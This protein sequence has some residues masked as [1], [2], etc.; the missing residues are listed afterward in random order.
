MLK[1]SYDWG[2]HFVIE[3]NI[4]DGIPYVP[5]MGGG[6]FSSNDYHSKGIE[7]PN[8]DHVIFQYTLAGSCI[9][10]YGDTE[11]EVTA[12][13][14]FLCF[15]NDPLMSYR[16]NEN[17]DEN[18]Q[19]IYTAISG[20]HDFFRNLINTYGP[21]YRMDQTNKWFQR[22]NANWKD[23]VANECIKISFEENVSMI[24][25][26][27]AD[28]LASGRA[29]NEAFH[30]ESKIINETKRL[31]RDNQ[32]HHFSVNSLANALEIS[33][34]HLTRKC[35][36]E[37]QITAIQLIDR[38]KVEQATLLLKFSNM[39]IKEIA[40]EIGFSSYSSFLRTFK[41]VTSISPA[42]FKKKL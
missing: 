15:A 20:N 27:V 42:R 35:K 29:G 23:T 41:R 5:F 17:K 1:G 10:K 24:G 4:I 21:I 7:R 26:L 3:G 9:F 28:V 36:E 25:D 31:L 2:I 39:S 11:Y 13:S 8:D 6:V 16:Y 30:K 18:Y 14:A 38:I 40:Y 19:Q 22:V 34:Q 37:L 12:G 32:K 33:P